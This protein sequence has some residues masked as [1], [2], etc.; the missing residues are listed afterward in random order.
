MTFYHKSL[1]ATNA[2][3]YAKIAVRLGTEPAYRQSASEQII[4]KSE[5]V[6]SPEQTVRDYERFFES[7]LSP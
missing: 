6:F 2:E 7:V 3:E 4:Q 1:I 5:P